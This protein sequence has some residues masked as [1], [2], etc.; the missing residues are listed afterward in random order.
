VL[1]LRGATCSPFLQVT[2]VPGQP[3][4][5]KVVSF[6]AAGFQTGRYTM[7]AELTSSL[8]DGTSTASFSGEVTRKSRGCRRQAPVRAGWRARKSS[9]TRL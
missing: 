7:Y 4:E 1:P 6:Q 8:L 9:T 5:T 2:S 3:G